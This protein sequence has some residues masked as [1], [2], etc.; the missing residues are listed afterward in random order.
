MDRLIFVWFYAL[1]PNTIKA[2]MIVKQGN[3]PQ[4]FVTRG[5]SS[6]SACSFGGGNGLA[7]APVVW[8][9]DSAPHLHPPGN[10]IRLILS[11][12]L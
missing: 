8:Q 4:K 5:R 1:V 9:S 11:V 12:I 2:L 10:V 3:R 6:E 7:L